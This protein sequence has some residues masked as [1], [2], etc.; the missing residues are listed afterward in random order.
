MNRSTVVTPEEISA[1]EAALEELNQAMTQLEDRVSGLSRGMDAT[2]ATVAQLEQIVENIENE[3]NS[4][5]H[6]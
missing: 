1:L 5:S 2:E 4:D 3:L 6:R